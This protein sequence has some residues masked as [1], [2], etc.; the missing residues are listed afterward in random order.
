MQLSYFT[1]I[2]LVYINKSFSDYNSLV[3]TII[4]CQ[5]KVHV[6]VHVDP[7]ISTYRYTR[8]VHRVRS[9]YTDQFK[10]HDLTQ[11]SISVGKLL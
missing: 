11:S 2:L 6:H 4:R 1:T 8:T 3:L 9:D 7:H 5:L 10:R